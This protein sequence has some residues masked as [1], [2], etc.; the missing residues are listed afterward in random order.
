MALKTNK[1]LLIERKLVTLPLIDNKNKQK[2]NAGSNI[3]I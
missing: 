2:A 1:V 3:G